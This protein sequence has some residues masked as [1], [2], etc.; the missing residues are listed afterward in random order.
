MDI[1][2][3]A[4]G[5]RSTKRSRNSYGIPLIEFS[6]N[7]ALRYLSFVPRILRFNLFEALISE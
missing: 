7:R 3:S 6:A 5:A 1:L 4:I 2:L